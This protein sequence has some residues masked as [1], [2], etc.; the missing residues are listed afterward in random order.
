MKQIIFI[1]INNEILKCLN[2]FCL[3]HLVYNT[4]SLL[5]LSSFVGIYVNQCMFKV[6]IETLNFVL[7]NIKHNVKRQI[8]KSI[9]NGITIIKSSKV[10]T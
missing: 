9:F 3:D 10:L 4:Y 2:L 6:L 8:K 5:S 1:I 7:I